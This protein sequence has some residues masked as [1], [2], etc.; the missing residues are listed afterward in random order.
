MAE[1]IVVNITVPAPQSV[2]LVY[3]PI[4][5]ELF[6]TASQGTKADAA[7]PASMTSSGFGD[8]SDAGHAALYDANGSLH[9]SELISYRLGSLPVARLSIDGGES[10]AYLSLANLSGY[11]SVLKATNLTSTRTHQ[12]PNTSGNL[13]LCA[14]VYGQIT[15]SDVTGLGSLA[16]QNGT[17]SLAGLGAA[18]AAGSSSIVSLGS[19]T[20]GSWAASVIPGQYGGTGVANTGKTITLAGN[21]ITTGAFN[22]TFAQSATTTV[23][24]PAT[25]AT[26]AR[27][28]AAQTFAGVQTFTSPPVF[29]A[30]PRIM[31]YK[32]AATQTTVA[33]SVTY[34]D[35]VFDVE[36]YDTNNN[37]AASTFTA[38]YACFVRVSGALYISGG[39]AGY[40]EVAIKV[41]GTA[42]KRLLHQYI[43][44]PFAL[45]FS[46]LVHVNAGDTL[47]LGYSGENARQLYPAQTISFISIEVLP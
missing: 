19:V 18:P 36:E 39:T 23:T 41:N 37:F 3:L 12:A 46:G 1:S 7:L 43:S 10:D 34:S 11:A 2:A 25:S 47:T 6:A 14:S 4:A 26:M 27:T 24:L 21:L 16:G 17:F 29:S 42:V 45:N 20:S 9:A 30:L 22:T 5:A 31:A 35:V 33:G 40:D 15:I 38:P 13:A 28:D 8:V 44:A 32:S